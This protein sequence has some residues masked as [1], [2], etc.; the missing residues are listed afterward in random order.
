VGR[1]S[2]L[3]NFWGQG[4]NFHKVAFPQLTG[5]W[6]EDASAAR[7]AVF[8]DD[9]RSIVV[10]ADVGSVGTANAM[11]GPYDHRFH[12]VSLFDSAARG[13]ALYGAY[14]YVTNPGI[15]T[16]GTTQYADTQKFFGAGIVSHTQT[17]L[18]LNHISS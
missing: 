6:A 4:Y 17:T 16:G 8:S 12:N 18:L 9:Y 7:V 11:F 13:G 14:D 15:A 5:H 2:A 1:F 10:K 3:E